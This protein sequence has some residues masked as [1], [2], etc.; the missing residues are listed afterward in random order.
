M[1]RSMRNT[2]FGF[3]AGMRFL[4]FEI[5]RVAMGGAALGLSDFREPFRNY[6]LLGFSSGN[7][8]A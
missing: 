1:L 5:V 7:D 2:S 3:V 4:P 8:H 6:G